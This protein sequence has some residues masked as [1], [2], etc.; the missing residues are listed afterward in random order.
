MAIFKSVNNGQK[1]SFSLSSALNQATTLRIATTL[2]FA[3]GRPQA[4]VNGFSCP[5][6]GAPAKIDSRGVTRGAYRGNGEV[7]TCT[8]PAGTLVSGTN[9]VTINVISGSD[10]ATFLS[11][12]VVSTQKLMVTTKVCED[13]GLTELCCRSSM[14]LSCSIDEHNIDQQDPCYA[15]SW[16]RRVVDFQIHVHFF[17]SSVVYTSRWSV[18][19]IMP[20]IPFLKESHLHARCDFLSRA[21]P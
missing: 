9:T 13:R 4:S 18:Y 15:L 5:A 6:P 17:A 3:G 16:S 2:S 20:Y 10:G 8:V 1:I 7:Y 12:N 11:P 14:R 19:I 21:S